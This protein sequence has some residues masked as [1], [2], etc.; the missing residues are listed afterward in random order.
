MSNNEKNMNNLKPLTE[1]EMDT[2]N[3]E[4]IFST[5]TTT[6]EVLET[7]ITE[8][9]STVFTDF[10]GCKIIPA[11]QGE[12]SLKC[13]LYFRPCPETDKDKN[14]LYAINVPGTFSKTTTTGHRFSDTVKKF[15]YIRTA[16]LFELDNT[17]KEILANYL[18]LRE[19]EYRFEKR[20]SKKYN[21]EVRIKVPNNWN[22]YF[23]EESEPVMGGGRYQNMYACVVL[24]LL[25][26]VSALYGLKDK[27]KVKLGKEK[28]FTPKNCYQY[29]VNLVRVL[30]PMQN[31]FVIEIKRLD[32][33]LLDK[34]SKEVGFGLSIQPGN[35]VMT[36]K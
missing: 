29:S 4:S 28:G 35:I 34:L 14:K 7:H 6:S 25:P 18:V 1:V 12:N 22:R 13:K 17:A 32:T 15:N 33:E 2:L 11:G 24:D 30:N 9:F 27:E 31:K 23:G 3:F 26:I 21:N 5:A 10:E 36:R 16:K 20:Y 8:F 19:G